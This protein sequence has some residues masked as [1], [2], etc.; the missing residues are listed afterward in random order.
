MVK[1][2]VDVAR[3]TNLYFYFL[4]RLYQDSKLINLAYLSYGYLLGRRVGLCAAAL[5]SSHLS[6]HAYL[7]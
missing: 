4:L 1:I 3:P 5:D 6:L 2:R 7:V